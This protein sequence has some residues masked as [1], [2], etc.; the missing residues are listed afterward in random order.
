MSDENKARF[1]KDHKAFI[2]F[3]FEK[4]YAIDRYG[5]LTDAAQFE[6]FCRYLDIPYQR[7][8]AHPLISLRRLESLYLT[9]E[10]SF[11]PILIAD[12]YTNA[13]VRDNNIFIELSSTLLHAEQEGAH[14][15]VHYSDAKGQ[16]L[17]IK[18]PQVVNATYASTNTINDMFGLEHIDLQHEISEIA[19]LSAPLVGELGLTIMDGPFASL[20]PYGKTGL[21]SLSSVAYTH[22]K[23]SYEA[24][25]TF[26]CQ[27]KTSDCNPGMLDDCNFCIA[28][29]RSNREKMLAQIR[30]YF[31]TAVEF[32]YFSSLYT[33]K[34]KLQANFIDDGRPT[35]I[36]SL[37]E[38]PAFYCIFAGKINSI[39]E[40][41]K[42]LKV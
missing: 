42:V 34:S 22:H 14:W 9:Q 18:T 39:Y 6:R 26:S 25:P 10:Y 8:G 28:Q 5:S 19:L 4:Y 30:Q 2:N 1:T 12:F 7:V 33:V 37:H 13:L 3:T 15:L 29:P 16:E 11:D 41:E 17:L 36:K 21:L 32:H 31:N 38:K 24:M 23:V 27:E 40:V 35:E 20:M